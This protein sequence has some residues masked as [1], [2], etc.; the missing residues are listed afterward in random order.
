MVKFSLDIHHSVIILS[1]TEFNTDKMLIV[2]AVNVKMQYLFSS[3]FSQIPNMKQ[4]KV[5]RKYHIRHC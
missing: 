4:K 1:H 2:I 3:H 5:L